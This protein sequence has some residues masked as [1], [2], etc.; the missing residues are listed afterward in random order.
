[1]LKNS[2]PNRSV[3][4]HDFSRADKVNQINRALAP[5]GR[6]P[7][8]LRSIAEFFNKLLGEGCG[9]HRFAVLY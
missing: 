8:Q 3:T 2:E 1:L 9:D 6:L 4:G 7:R 5:A